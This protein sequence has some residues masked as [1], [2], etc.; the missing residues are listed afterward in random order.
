MYSLQLTHPF[1][2]LISSGT[3]TEKTTFVKQL[4]T[5]AQIMIDPSP[6]N[7]V[8]FYS[9]YQ[10]TFSEREQVVPG[11][12]FIQGVPDSIFD[13][14]NPKMRNLYIFD[15]MIGEKDAIIAR[16]FTKKSHHGNLSVVYIVQ[17]LLHQSKDH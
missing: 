15:D 5:N 4:L 2:L 14:I 13:S 16:L 9:E 1:G 6:E 17:N 7:I 11:I 8:Y 3:K 12:Q 10:D